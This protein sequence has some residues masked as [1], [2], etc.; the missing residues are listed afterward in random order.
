MTLSSY[1]NI[2]S[3]YYLMK[4]V[5]G[6]NDTVPCHSSVDVTSELGNSTLVHDIWSCK[7]RVDGPAEDGGV[8]GAQRADLGHLREAEDLENI[9]RLIN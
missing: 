1:Q 3:T 9:R 6:M 2:D 7:L 8:G 5:I 4:K